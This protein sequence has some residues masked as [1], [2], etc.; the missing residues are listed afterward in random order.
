MSSPFR[1][2]AEAKEISEVNVV[3]LADVS[4]VLLII[5]MVLSP[6][7][8]QSMLMVKTAAQPKALEHEKEPLPPP[9]EKQDMILAVSLRPDGVMVGNKSFTTMASFM[10][11]MS[12]T[13]NARA[14]DKKV[15]LTPHPDITNGKVVNMIEL[16]KSCGAESVALVQTQDD[17]EPPS[18][19][20]PTNRPPGR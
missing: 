6:M 2:E 9:P 5:L 20:M 7:M 19:A 10:S 12:A 17:S 3:P 16:L 18:S 15:F 8:V 11:Y 4:L 1:R 13:L 14:T